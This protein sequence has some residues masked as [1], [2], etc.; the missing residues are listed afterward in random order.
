MAISASEEGA[1]QPSVIFKNPEI[2]EEDVFAQNNKYLMWTSSTKWIPALFYKYLN[3]D[4]ALF[5]VLFTY[6]QTTFLLLAVYCLSK[7][8][9]KNSGTGLISVSLTIILSPY[10]NNLG[11]YGDL[12][13]M[14]YSTWISI[15]PLLFCITYLIN[16]NYI[17]SALFYI[18]GL[19]V[20][21]AMAITIFGLIFA[22]IFAEKTSTYRQKFKLTT[23]FLIPMVIT[24]FQILLIQH[25]GSANTVPKSWIAESKKLFHWSA[26]QLN[27]QSITFKTTSYTIC[28]FIATLL[29]VIYF[30][31]LGKYVRT[32]TFLYLM[33]TFISMFIQAVA[34]VVNIRG[35]YTINF[36][37]VT[38][39]MSIF[40]VIIFSNILYQQ[41][42]E[43]KKLKTVNLLL[44]IFILIQSY[45]ML[46]IFSTII[47]VLIHRQA[48]N[49]LYRNIIKI[50]VVAVP[51]SFTILY[52]ATIAK[53]WQLFL[54][55]HLI[56][57]SLLLVP[58]GIAIRALVEVFGLKSLFLILASLLL[59][60]V[61]KMKNERLIRPIT[62][63]V[64]TFLVLVTLSIRYVQSEIRF[65][66][67]SQWATTQIWVQKNTDFDAKFIVDGSLDT[68][69]SWTTLTRRPRLT[70]VNG[71]QSFYIY[72]KETVALDSIRN[73]VGISP[74]VYADSIS[75][76]KFYSN[77][78]E[79][80]GGDFLVRRVAWTQLQWE[81]TYRNSH[82]VVYKIPKTSE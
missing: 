60:V 38:I 39:F 58:N 65:N 15:P 66:E 62:L 82:Y 37:R 24:S 36:T 30:K 73:T 17:K 23:L 18:L 20:H 2:F 41:L 27:P 48:K 10:F 32:I 19:S 81:V 70:S 33:I 16:K 6:S 45:P 49:I 55:P 4:P 34:F 78:S 69:S 46:I 26:W 79:I 75:L 3:I 9:F 1:I 42:F 71:P 29:A 47:L 21:P 51:I 28:L 12:Y 68:Y 76:E 35:L 50:L 14:P 43:Y 25:F 59:L 44:I 31:N 54:S 57:D 53:K 22:T 72:T 5:H 11:S 8:L 74:D 7:T 61:I 77:F 64:I 67:N 63:V 40:S 13:F 56:L 80:F 52:F